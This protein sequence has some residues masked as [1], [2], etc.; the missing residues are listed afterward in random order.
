[1]IHTPLYLRLW[2]DEEGRGFRPWTEDQTFRRGFNDA[3]GVRTQ[4]N[5]RYFSGGVRRRNLSNYATGPAPIALPTT[6]CLH[7]A[8]IAPTTGQA[9]TA[10][11]IMVPTVRRLGT[12]LA[13]EFFEWQFSK[14][15][16]RKYVFRKLFFRN[17]EF[18]NSNFLKYKDMHD[19]RLP[20]RIRWDLL[21]S[22]ISRS[23][24]LPK[25]R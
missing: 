3:L 1:M 9:M 18:I 2:R 10:P 14:N 23:N 25:F 21:S 20:P 22:G 24:S 16:F 7:S 15:K 8:T 11:G 4:P 12:F 5:A 6:H 13:N 19:F 17:V